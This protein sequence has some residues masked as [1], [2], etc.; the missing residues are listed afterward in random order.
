MSIKKGKKM[1]TIQIQTQNSDIVEAIKALIRLDPK[2]KIIFDKSKN[3][4]E[5]LSSYESSQS[6]E[7]I[8]KGM[9]KDIELYKIG[10]LDEFEEFGKDWH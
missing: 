7:N 6:Y 2:S 8:K 10:D 1:M 5:I 9:Q 4:D 3:L